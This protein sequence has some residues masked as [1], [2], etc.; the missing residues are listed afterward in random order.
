MGVLPKRF[1][2]YGL[3]LHPDKTRLIDFRRPDTRTRL[4]GEIRAEGPTSFD[5]LAF[6]HVWG[7]SRHGMWVMRQLTAK[8]RFARALRKVVDF[9][10]EHRH[11]P[12]KEQHR[13]L[14]LKVRGHYG[15]FGLTGNMRRVS[16]FRKAVRSA[17]FT[18]L[19]RRAQ[20]PSLTGNEFD[21]LELRWPLPPPCLP[22]SVFRRPA[23]A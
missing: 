23:R 21:R 9:V 15:Y 4:P 8:D 18:W 12:I 20:M 19:N 10:R 11:M 7:R 14:C 6:T 2:K 13:L 3:T 5:F 17:W 22:R 16:A 1:E